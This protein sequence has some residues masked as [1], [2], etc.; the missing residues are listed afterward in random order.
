MTKQPATKSPLSPFPLW[1][2]SRQ[3]AALA[4]LIRLQAAA[5]AEAE[6]GVA[7][8]SEIFTPREME[9]V[10]PLLEEPNGKRRKGRQG[11]ALSAFP[12]PQC[13]ASCGR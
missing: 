8:K 9:A 13:R 4:K 1:L 2:T 12:P 6:G 11:L 5:Y 3:A 10:L 7:R